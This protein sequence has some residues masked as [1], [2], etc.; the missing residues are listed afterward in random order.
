MARLTA[1][2][3]AVLREIVA[4]QREVGLRSATDGEFR[5]ASWHMDFIYAL[6]GIG[7]ADETMRVEFHNE[8]GDHQGK[9]FIKV[10]VPKGTA[11]RIDDVLVVDRFFRTD[12]ADEF[13]QRKARPDGI[14][15]RRPRSG[16]CSRF[17]RPPL[18]G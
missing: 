8:N 4:M 6:G 18:T 11:V 2:Q 7:Q 9:L 17:W 3:S 14:P 15:V 10:T 1:L 5:R 13:H 16:R 12:L